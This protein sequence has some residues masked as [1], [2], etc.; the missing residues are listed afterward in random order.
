MIDR[1]VYMKQIIPFI[2]KNIIKILVGVRRSG[3]STLLAQIRDR[4]LSEGVPE[5]S[6]L[7]INFESAH[8]SD[9]ID[10][11]TLQRYVHEHLPESGKLYAF[12]DEIQEIEGWEKALRSF[13]VDYDMDI[14]VTGSNAHL[15]S[16]ELAT[17]ITGRY[18][19]IPVYPFSFE[20]YLRASNAKQSGV[21]S[22]SSSAAGDDESSAPINQS[23][24]TVFDAKQR[25]SLSAT[26]QEAFRDY[27]DLGGFPFRYDL[28]F[29]GEP[30]LKY[31]TDIYGTIMLKDVVQRSAVRDAN[32]LERILDF[33]IE[34]V[35]HTLSVKSVSNY[36]KSDGRSLSADTIYSYL[37]AAEDAC[38]LYKVPREDA[39]GKRL[40]RF[41]EKYYIVDQGL[42]KA[43]GFSNANA[44]D[45]V[46]E[47]IVYIELLRRGY[48]VSVGKVGDREIDFI[49]EKGDLR[50]Y[51]QVAYL[52]A[53][54]S[55]VE[56][57]FSALKA[58]SDNYPKYVL[59]LDGFQF[60]R[61]GICSV[62]LI[63]W[64]LDGEED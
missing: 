2:G 29:Q 28:D 19:Q 14:Y 3:K 16:G 62:N 11:R 40:L 25:A 12:F 38:L 43:R 17:H 54:E 47:N 4:L 30:S 50:K 61:N 24:E 7:F 60:S 22:S 37:K 42:R 10:A 36:L 52:L 64:L 35:G 46:L 31:L 51:Y 56:R 49:A 32:Q 48:R 57:E 58:V 15:F 39:V 41:N 1:P 26:Y 9:I 34:Q 6:M 59:S 13:L 5:S 45:Q 27:L 53:E 20:E 8:F 44:I 55:T 23:G 18:V 21:E 63:D 33:A